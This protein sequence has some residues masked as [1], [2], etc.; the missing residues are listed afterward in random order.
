MKTSQLTRGHKRRVM[1]VECKDGEVDGAQA[2]IA[3]VEF[4]KSGRTVYFKGRSLVRAKGGGVSGNF[5]D[6]DSGEEFWISGIKKRGSN[7]HPAESAVRVL[8]DSDAKEEYERIRND[9]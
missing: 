2:W 9:V 4:S 1:Y 6:T 5:V 3:W 8:I 7:T